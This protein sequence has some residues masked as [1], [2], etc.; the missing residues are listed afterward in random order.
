M[1]N[2]QV[3]T[4]D[5]MVLD[6]I[7]S[8]SAAIQGIAC[9]ETWAEAPCSSTSVLPSS[10]EKRKMV[11]TLIKHQRDDGVHQLK[12]RRLQLQCEHLEILD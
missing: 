2:H 12:K 1:S 9:R 7:G 6:V 3:T 4:I 8:E 5:N 10:A 11:A